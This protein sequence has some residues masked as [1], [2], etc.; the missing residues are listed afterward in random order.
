MPVSISP[1]DRQV[2]VITLKLRAN[3]RQEFAVML[4]DRADA[5][6]VVVV[7]GNFQQPFA[8]NVSAS[9]HVFEER[10]NIVPAFWTAE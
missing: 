10:Q 1:I 5:A 8:R 7:L 4:V 2:D 3:R 6:E 9:C